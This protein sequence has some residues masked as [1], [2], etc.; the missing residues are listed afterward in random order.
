MARR[1][2]LLFKQDEY[3]FLHKVYLSKPSKSKMFV[4]IKKKG[5]LGLDKE[6]ILFVK[7]KCAEWKEKNPNALLWMN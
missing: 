7:K 6:E 5:G 1:N 4:N 2:P 3:K